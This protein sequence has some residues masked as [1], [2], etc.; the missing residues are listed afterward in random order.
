MP[1]DH[2]PQLAISHVP[3]P[4]ISRAES[5]FCRY[6]DRMRLDWIAAALVAAGLGAVGCGAST[7][8][9]DAQA[10]SA[11]DGPTIGVDPETLPAGHCDTD[12]ATGGDT[13]DC[14]TEGEPSGSAAGDEGG[15]TAGD[16]ASQPECASTND[17]MSGVCASAYDADAQQ[18]LPATCA[19][20]CIDVLNESQWCIDDASCCDPQ[21]RCTRRGYCVIDDA[22][23]STTVGDTE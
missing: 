12:G 22:S 3:K 10:S 23:G 7:E 21:A 11:A 18:P 1:N 6:R 2:D 5:A 4:W 8:E 13:D 16:D 14:E 20:A 17:C 19:F 15:S 9:D